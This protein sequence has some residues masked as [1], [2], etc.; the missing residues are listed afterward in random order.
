MIRRHENKLH[1]IYFCS[2]R[3]LSQN[4]WPGMPEI[5]ALEILLD[6]ASGL[7]STSAIYLNLDI[8]TDSVLKTVSW[9]TCP[10]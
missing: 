9:L 5:V 6:S 10:Y 4:R 2:F 7:S 3:V 1:H 8:K